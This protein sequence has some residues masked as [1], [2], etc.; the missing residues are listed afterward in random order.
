MADAKQITMFVPVDLLARIDEAAKQATGRNNGRT[1][2]VLDAARAKLGET[3][4]DA[5]LARIA[6]CYARMNEDGRAFLAECAQV[7]SERPA[8]RA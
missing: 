1:E 8:H 2:W 4:E 6:A 5:R 3:G 7:A